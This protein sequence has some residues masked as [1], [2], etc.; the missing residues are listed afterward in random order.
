MTSPGKDVSRQSSPALY[1]LSDVISVL[2]SDVSCWMSSYPELSLGAACRGNFTHPVFSLADVGAVLLWLVGGSSSSRL[3]ATW[4]VRLGLM[5][6]LW[7]LPGVI[8]LPQLLLSLQHLKPNITLSVF[9]SICFSELYN[10]QMSL[11]SRSW[12]FLEV[13]I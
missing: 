1:Q 11:R 8:L 7:L 4:A 12:F 2:L 3:Y 10:R 6:S 9:I 5:S 13:I